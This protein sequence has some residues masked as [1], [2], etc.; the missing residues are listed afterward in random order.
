MISKENYKKLLEKFWDVASWAIW[1]PATAGYPKSNVGDLKIF[2]DPDLLKKINT[3]F[4]FVG[5]NCPI[6]KIHSSSKDIK[7]ISQHLIKA[8]V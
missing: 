1:M 3:G 4:V 5:L 6:S 2:N 8:S 7:T